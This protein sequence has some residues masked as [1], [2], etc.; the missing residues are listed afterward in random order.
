MA[1][2]SFSGLASGLDSKAII[3]ALVG[4]AT[5]PKTR[6]ENQNVAYNNKLRI[7]DQL[8]SALASLRSAAD[9]MGKAGDFLSY[10]GSVSDTSVA[11]VTTTG[12]SV[13]GTY[14]L[15]VSSLA[16][17]QRTYSDT[18][19]DADA[20]LSASDQTLSLTIDG[21]QTDISIAAGSSLRD[22][23]AAINASGAKAT[24]GVMFDGNNYRL[25]VVGRDTGADNAITFTDSG[26]SLGLSTA[27]NTVQAA[28]DASF[29]LDGFAM[30]SASN[31]VD[32]VLPGTTLELTHTTSAAVDVSISA[33]PA[34]VK[35]KLQKFVDSYNQVAK[36]IR[37]QSGQGKG[38]ETLNGDSTVRTI[39]QGLQRMISSPISGL[40][41]PGGT[42]LQLTDL[43][44]QTQRDGSLTLN[45]TDLDTKLAADFGQAA[46][47]FA[48]DG[49]N[50]GMTAMLDDLLDSYTNSTDGLL[51]TRK[52][53]I[54]SLVDDN[55]KQIDDMQAYLD[56]YEETLQQQY[57]QLESTMSALNSQTSY[58][59]RFL[60]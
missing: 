23:A 16:R 50:D 3:S 10:T 51:S 58:L 21:T 20:E 52:K 48:G 4:V 25:Q 40:V 55:S 37:D 43:G 35:A 45:T 22:V 46:T 41:G 59:A 42:S 24:A 60:N 15:E 34:G 26:L 7:V 31:V 57:A 18:F 49:T 17:A 39:E 36:I 27:A 32:G 13:P 44:I 11:K 6:L 2:I 47:Y 53:G 33:D 28:T 19:A 14:S 1:A 29:T 8:S 56:R 30:T 9:A 12:D 5:I 54:Q 38:V